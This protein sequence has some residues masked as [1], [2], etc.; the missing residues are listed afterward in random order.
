M[1]KHQRVAECKFDNRGFLKEVTRVEQEKFL[2][3][4]TR[5][6]GM[7]LKYSLQNWLLF[8]SLSA[9]RK[10]IASLREFYGTMAF[11]SSNGISLFDTYWFSETGEDEWDR[12]N[13][14]ENWDCKKDSF[15]LMQTH[16][17]KVTQIHRDSPNLTVPG[18]APRIWY[19]QDGQFCLLSEDAKEMNAYKA[20]ADYGHLMK[21][22]YV[23]LGEKIYVKQ[24]AQ[25]SPKIECLSFDGYFKEQMDPSLSKGKNLSRCCNYFEIPGWKDFLSSMLECDKK[26]GN[27]ER[28]LH[29]IGVLRD[30]DTLEIIGFS[31]L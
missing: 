14:F 22:S 21:R 2:P 3:P 9:N 8:R 28:E 11:Y 24:D 13:A 27:Q 17:Q 15:Y 19:K 1:H 12:V 16:P 23:L 20:G 30:A 6:D 29:D 7:N 5:I 26:Q 31:K 10:E 25:T 4:G 18:C